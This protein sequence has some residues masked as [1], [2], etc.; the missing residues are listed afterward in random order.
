[1]EAENKVV[2]LFLSDKVY[3]KPK[4]VSRDKEINYLAR[5]REIHLEGLIIINIGALNVIKQILVNIRC[6]IGSYTG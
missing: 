6:P 1:M 2:L 3:S 4:S 5:S